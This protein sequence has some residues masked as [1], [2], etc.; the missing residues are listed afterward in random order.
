MNPREGCVKR[1]ERSRTGGNNEFDWTGHVRALREIDAEERPRSRPSQAHAPD[2]ARAPVAPIP[3]A[4]PPAP[5]KPPPA[6]M[7]HDTLEIPEHMQIR[8]VRWRLRG[9]QDHYDDGVIDGANG[10]A[11]TEY[12]P[13]AK[14]D[15]ERDDMYGR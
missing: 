14:F 7:V 1:L 13:F 11:L 4:K 5:A 3:A 10:Q 2:A 12:D 6:A 8:P 15:E 9:P